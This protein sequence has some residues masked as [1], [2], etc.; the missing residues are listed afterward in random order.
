MNNTKTKNRNKMKPKTVSGC[1]LAKQNVKRQKRG[2]KGR[3]Q[4]TAKMLSLM[5]PNNLYPENRI[6]REKAL[7]NKK[8][9]SSTSTGSTATAKEATSTS[10]NSTEINK[11]FVDLDDDDDEV[12]DFLLKSLD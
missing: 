6:A 4:P 9:S 10:G 5:N 12:N 7:E 3:F 11:L 2:L 8:S 1:L